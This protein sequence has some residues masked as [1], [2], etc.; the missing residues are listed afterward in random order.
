MSTEESKNILVADDSIFFRTKLS[1]ILIVAGHK[2]KFANNGQE[3]IDE[4]K[5]NADH[6]DLLILDLQM[7]E[8]DG[9]G[10]ME[11]IQNSGH[12]GKFPILVMTG[13]F[14]ATHVL[15]KIKDVQGDVARADYHQGQQVPFS[16][17]HG[18]ENRAVFTEDSPIFMCAG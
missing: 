17:K 9:F 8:V 10:V 2:V 18:R 1:D 7:P 3:A 16:V 4:V 6:I 12:G 11:W 15:D 13:A 14:E 5:V